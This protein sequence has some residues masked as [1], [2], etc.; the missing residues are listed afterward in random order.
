MSGA[1]SSRLSAARRRGRMAA[2][3]QQ[4]AMPVDWVFS[5]AVLQ[6]T[7]EAPLAACVPPRGS[8]ETGYIVGHNVTI[9]FRSLDGQYD[10]LPAI[11]ADLV[12]Q[13]VSVLVT[14]DRRVRAR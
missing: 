11:A 2:R 13:N 10:R 1:S 14:T 3:A 12:R 9:E 6:A 8:S 4:P 5:A 7:S